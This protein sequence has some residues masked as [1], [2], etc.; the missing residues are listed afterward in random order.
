M[1]TNQTIAHVF[2]GTVAKCLRGSAFIC[3]GA[4][5][6]NQTVVHETLLGLGA[7][8]LMVIYFVICC[9]Y[10]GKAE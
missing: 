2:W 4:I 7:L 8:L 9:R 5:F 6:F 10:L 1:K 3:G